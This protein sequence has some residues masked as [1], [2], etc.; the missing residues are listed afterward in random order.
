MEKSHQQQQQQQ[1]QRQQ[2]HQ[3][4]A[5]PAGNADTSISTRHADQ[6][7]QAREDEPPRSETGG[8]TQEMGGSIDWPSRPW[9]SAISQWSAWD[10]LAKHFLG[11]VWVVFRTVKN[12]WMDARC[13]GS[14][15]D[16][17]RSENQTKTVK[18]T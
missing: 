16:K 8:G 10:R 12:G 14:F 2:Q 17:S 13:L 4:L 1:Q 6:P 5:S 9:S 3:F 11:L 7:D 18:S 15:T